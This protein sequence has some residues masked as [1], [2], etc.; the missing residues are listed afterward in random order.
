MLNIEKYMNKKFRNLLFVVLLFVSN[1]ACSNQKDSSL[2]IGNFKISKVID[3]DTFRFENLD[4]SARLLGID[5]EETFK[6]PDA[7]QKTNEIAV[8]WDEFY[9]SEKGSNKFPVKADSPLGFEGWKWAE[10]FFKNVDFVRLEKEEDDRSLDIFGRYLVYAIAVMKDGTE[11]NYNVECVKN[12]YSPYFNK[13]GNSKRFH[14]EFVSAQN[15]AKE[16]KLG[17]WNPEKK[18]Y[19][20]YDE[21][22]IWWNTRADQLDNYEKKYSS[23]ENYFNLAS[24]T[25]FERLQNF[26]GKEVIVF[27]G[28]GQVLS[29]KQPVLLRIPHAKDENFDIVVF[30][31]NAGLLTELD[32]DNK[33]EYYIYLKGNLEIYNGSYQIVLRD[34]NQLWVE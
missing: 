20:D 9:K 19:P 17:I 7:E 10:E 27:G 11:I 13:Y 15:Y 21:R 6:T 5:A 14:D 30:P 23:V 26:V 24:D 29:D 8:N 28:I 2:I 12:G 25:D 4:K 16:N 22:L 34:I 32:I 33:K 3:A 1:I 31:E 18:H